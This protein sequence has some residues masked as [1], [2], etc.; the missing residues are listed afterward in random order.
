MSQLVTRNGLT[1]KALA[2]K[3]V[4]FRHLKTIGSSFPNLIELR[5]L[6]LQSKLHYTVGP[7][8]QLL[9]HDEFVEG[10]RPPSEDSLDFSGLSKL[11]L[12][13]INSWN[14]RDYEGLQDLVDNLLSASKHIKDLKLPFC[15]LNSRTLLENVTNLCPHLEAFTM[16]NPEVS[17]KMLKAYDLFSFVS[18]T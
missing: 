14:Q 8:L 9:V 18:S 3:P 6:R 5:I 15:P 1:L 4:E 10:F 7:F 2:M 12:L 13:H 17:Y 16:V 11:T